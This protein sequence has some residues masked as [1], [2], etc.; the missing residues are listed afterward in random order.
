M[1]SRTKRRGSSSR[2][3][4]AAPAETNSP[5]DEPEHESDPAV[6]SAP[7]ATAKPSRALM[8]AIVAIA[9]IWGAVLLSLVI[10]SANPVTLNRRQIE[11]SDAVVTARV[12]DADEGTVSIERVWFAKA[13][14]N[15]KRDDSLT[16][17]RLQQ[18]RAR[19]GRS[20]LIPLQRDG[21]R[22]FRV[23]PARDQDEKPPI[24]PASESAIQQ[25]TQ[26]AEQR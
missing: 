6:G 24:Y 13:A 7:P 21:E 15:I 10:F 14:L 22:A 20:Y 8:K 11:R 9:G 25:I 4:D 19:N 1:S 26:I 17:K 12:T 18:S 3:N 16:V 2:R 23:T 5:T